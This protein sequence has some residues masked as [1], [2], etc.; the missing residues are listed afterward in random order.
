[1]NTGRIPERLLPAVLCAVLAL[2]AADLFMLRRH[3]IPVHSKTLAEDIG[4][5]ADLD[6]D[7]LLVQWN[8]R[9]RMVVN[10]D[11]AIL[12]IQDGAEQK[13][14]ELTGPQL[15]RSSVRYW[16]ETEQVSFR[17]VVYRGDQLGSD[18]ADAKNYRR[19]HDRG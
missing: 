5:H 1:M 18:S 14:L 8:R 2:G 7:A 19:N 11:R 17:L 3:R 16:P 6:G 9:A 13:K 4:L 15:D 12:H 10:A